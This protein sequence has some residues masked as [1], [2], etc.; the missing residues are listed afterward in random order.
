MTHKYIFYYLVFYGKSLL[1]PALNLALFRGTVNSTFCSINFS[2]T[3]A[4]DLDKSNKIMMKASN[5]P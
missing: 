5:N 4:L 1:R 2:L 3:E